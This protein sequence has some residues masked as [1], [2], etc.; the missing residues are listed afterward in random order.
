MNLLLRLILIFAVGGVSLSHARPAGDA[1]LKS[2]PPV[3]PYLRCDK[4]KADISLV[5]VT[6]IEGVSA[7]KKEALYFRRATVGSEIPT[8]YHMSSHA[9]GVSRTGK[10][11]GYGYSILVTPVEAGAKIAIHATWTLE[12]GSG[13]GDLDIMVPYLTDRTGSIP[14]LSYSSRW[15]KLR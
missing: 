7:E 4:D 12:E 3:A 10:G 9:D 14:G 15:K 11:V 1:S 2:L 5:I 13:S 6:K 8:P